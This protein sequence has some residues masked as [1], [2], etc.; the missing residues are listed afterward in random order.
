MEDLEEAEATVVA[1]TPM[2]MRFVSTFR[3]SEDSSV[4]FC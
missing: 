3:F 2:G 1:A 4:R